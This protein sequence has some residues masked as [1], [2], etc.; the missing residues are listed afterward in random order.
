MV[1]NG[2]AGK[3]VKN[4]DEEFIAAAKHEFKWC[5]RPPKDNL[6]KIFE[7]A[8][9]HHPCPIKHKLMDCPMMRRFMSSIG[10]PPGSDE[11]ARDPRGRGIVLGEAE[12]TTITG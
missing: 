1:N 5:T 12:V 3:E 10:T 8:C 4:S 9:P 7:A 11:L 2:N 6:E